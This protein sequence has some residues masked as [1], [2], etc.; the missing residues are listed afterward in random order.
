MPVVWLIEAYR[1]G[2][3]GQVRA[4]VEALGWPCE[5]KK[6]EYRTLAFMPHVLGLSTLAGIRPSS[7]ELLQVFFL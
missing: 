7:R 6:L 3:R 1:A 4:L 2:E 5:S